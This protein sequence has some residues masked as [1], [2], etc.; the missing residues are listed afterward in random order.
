MN[1]KAKETDPV[2]ESTQVPPVLGLPPEPRRAGPPRGQTWQLIRLTLRQWGK[3]IWMLPETIAA[4]GK[5]RQRQ[6]VL[7]ALEVERLDRIR[8]PA[9]YRG[10]D[11]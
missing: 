5:Q 7:D 6:L 2:D 9:K 4:A 1:R 10:K 11:L 3:Q 8:N